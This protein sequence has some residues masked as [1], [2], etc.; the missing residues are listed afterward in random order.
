MKTPSFRELLVQPINLVAFGFGTGLSRVAPGTV[1]TLIGVGL[2]LVIGP[3]DLLWYLS[4]TI[5]ALIAGV[6]VCGSAARAFEVHDHPGIVWDEVVGYLITMTAL[7]RD[8]GWMVAGF[9]VFRV[10]DILKP[11]PIKVIDCR[12]RGGLGIM[13][14]DVLAGVVGCGLLH[15]ALALL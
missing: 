5:V 10:L 11:W 13:M 6:W 1:G 7:P 9:V 12:M 3:L 8:W 15:L 14:D 2:F 4:A